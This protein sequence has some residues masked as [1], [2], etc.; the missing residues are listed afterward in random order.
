LITGTLFAILQ[1]KKI[2]YKRILI[3][4]AVIL[5]GFLIR[6]HIVKLG[7]IRPIRATEFIL[8]SNPAN[9]HPMFAGWGMFLSIAFKF[10]PSKIHSIFIVNAVLGS[11][12][13][14]I[15]FYLVK[16]LSKNKKIAKICAGLWL[17]C[18]LYLIITTTESYTAPAIF[19]S[20]LTFLFLFK[21]LNKKKIP[22]FI[23]S[24]AFLGVAIMMRPEYIYLIPIYFITLISFNTNIDVK[25]IKLFI[26]IFF[27]LITPYF[28]A[29]VNGYSSLDWDKDLH[30]KEIDNTKWY[31]NYPLQ[32]FNLFKENIVPNLILVLF[33][34][35][36]ILLT[37]R[38]LFLIG[39]FIMIYRKD[40][41]SV[42]IMTYFL[43][44]FL[45]YVSMHQ[46][47]FTNGEH[48]YLPSLLIPVIISAGYAINRLTKSLPRKKAI[49]LIALIFILNISLSSIKISNFSKE[50]Q[51]SP[52]FEEYD[53]LKKIPNIKKSC[54]AIGN[55]YGSLL[56]FV[57]EFKNRAM[58]ESTNELKSILSSNP[59]CAYYY[60]YGYYTMEKDKSE[61]KLRIY[62]TSKIKQFLAEKGFIKLYS[63][64]MTFSQNKSD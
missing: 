30:G 64:E 61:G 49:T 29:L 20:L 17:I 8:Y 27:L 21:F 42:F 47:S 24:L 35:Q 58:V 6:I 45:T 40:K 50:R 2:K 43:I 10:L 19:F 3:P 11:I 52:F 57:F 44:V 55:G 56:P 12:S 34:D 54:L 48:K 7:F 28:I 13:P 16:E 59:P 60:Y 5:I 36:D 32:Y 25:K 18:P 31:Y 23:I 39:S 46:E 1:I 38:L 4:I 53:K 37:T 33:S 51:Q 62:N 15:V 9:Y 14:I 41:K 22:F 63:S 26:L